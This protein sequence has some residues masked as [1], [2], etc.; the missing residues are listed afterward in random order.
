MKK[1][2]LFDNLK[3]SNNELEKL[4]QDNSDLVKLNDKIKQIMM[5]K[6]I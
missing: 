4:K 6:L 2:T 1:N 3:V 5:K